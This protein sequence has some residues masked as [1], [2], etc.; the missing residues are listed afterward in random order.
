M[1][2]NPKLAHELRK[3]YSS[4]AMRADFGELHGW[5]VQASFFTD[6]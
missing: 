1:I 5:R 2:M 4:V 3:G 6:G